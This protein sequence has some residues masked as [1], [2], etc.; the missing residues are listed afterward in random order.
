MAFLLLLLSS[1]LLVLWYDFDPLV[2][3]LAWANFVS[4]TFQEISLFRKFAA[5][6][7][8][9]APEF[10]AFGVVHGALIHDFREQEIRD[11][12]DLTHLQ[13]RR[14]VRHPLSRRSQ[15]G[16]LEPVASTI[17]IREP[18]EGRHA[19]SWPS[20]FDDHDQVLPIE[21]RLSQVGAIRHLGVHLAAIARPAMARLAVGL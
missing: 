3:D 10:D 20:A 2:C 5:G 7:D 6:F 18:V 13:G 19:T 14:R 15:I 4:C 12:L 8:F 16:L 21:L 9:R 17:A 1:P 11:R